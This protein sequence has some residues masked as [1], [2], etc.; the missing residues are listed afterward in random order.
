MSSEGYISG[1]RFAR[2]T[3]LGTLLLT[4]IVAGVAWRW[5][6]PA[7]RGIAIGG[8]AG[9]L[10]FWMMARNART[11]T[12]IPKEEIP[13]RVYRWT[14]AR[15]ILYAMALFSAYLIDP[16]GR[17]ALLGAAGGL[18]IARVVMLVTAIVSWRRRGQAGAGGNPQ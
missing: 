9:A 4:P 16:V 8:I 3:F 12:S 7:A 17:N 15:I 13:F 10:G 1:A 6:P 14:F 18:F 5:D 11:L 2:A